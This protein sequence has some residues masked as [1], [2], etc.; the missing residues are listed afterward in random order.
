MLIFCHVLEK[1]D[2]SI[3]LKSFDNNMEYLKSLQFDIEEHYSE[4]A[5]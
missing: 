2:V 5:P 3:F 1:K 4:T